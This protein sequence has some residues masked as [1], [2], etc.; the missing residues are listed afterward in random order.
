VEWRA[1]GEVRGWD[2]E[3]VAG[4]MEAEGSEVGA[5]RPELR[6]QRASGARGV[7]GEYEDDE[8]REKHTERRKGA[9]A[10]IGR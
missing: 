5:R 1:T 3:D 9:G 2:G 6:R 8:S 10:G 7:E 4:A